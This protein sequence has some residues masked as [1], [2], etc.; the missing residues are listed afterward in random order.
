LLRSA[1]ELEGEE[2]QQMKAISWIVS[3][4]GLGEVSCRRSAMASNATVASDRRVCL[5]TDR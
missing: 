1:G 5:S 3:M 4:R 2:V